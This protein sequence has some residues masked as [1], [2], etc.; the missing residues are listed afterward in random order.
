MPIYEY[1]C[2]SCGAEFEEWQK[3]TDP[4]VQTCRS[5]G[6]TASRLI[7]QSSFVLKGTGWYVTDYARKDSSSA[8]RPEPKPKSAETASSSAGEA[9]KPAGP[10]PSTT[11]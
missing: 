3:I 9:A 5:C 7:S 2:R 1:R 4:A 10:S 6:G 8:P 11:E